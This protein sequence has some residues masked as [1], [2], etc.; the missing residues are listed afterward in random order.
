MA[1]V[2]TTMVSPMT[3]SKQLLISRRRKLLLLGLGMIVFIPL[4]VHKWSNLDVEGSRRDVTALCDE[5]NGCG[6]SA[7]A[8]ERRILIGGNHCLKYILRGTVFGFNGTTR[9]F[10]KTV[11]M[12]HLKT[13][14]VNVDDVRKTFLEIDN[15]FRF[16]FSSPSFLWYENKMALTLRLKLHSG[17]FHGQMCH[18]FMCNQ[19]HFGYY[20]EYLR[21]IG[22]PDII[23]LRT[24]YIPSGH[25]QIK[26]GPHDGK[27]FQMNGSLYILFATGIG[28]N[29][30]SSI[31]DFQ[32]QQ[33][34]TPY[35]MKRIM[36]RSNDVVM[37][38]NWVPVVVKDEL[39][40]IRY[41]D[42]LQVMK[43]KIH[44]GCRFVRNNTRPLAFKMKDRSFPIRG[45]TEFKEYQYPYYISI[46]HN[47]YIGSGERYYQANLVVM[48]V[49]PF[50][51]VYVS[52]RLRLK[53]NVFKGTKP[54][55]TTVAANFIFPTGLIIEDRNTIV[56]GAHAND[57]FSMLLRLTGI[58]PIVESVIEL[59]RGNTR[60]NKRLAIQR[61]FN[62][63][64]KARH[65]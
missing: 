9:I 11:Q 57:Q 64:S 48:C 50:R 28:E 41:L 39:Y 44:E 35:F 10:N 62:K 17:Y 32:R 63:R 2:F 13:F 47:T 61:F 1:S 58:Q 21:P 3:I 26:M 19:I 36:K 45:G 8:N 42:P 25:G 65:L 24:P 49:E 30:I 14:H 53:R 5:T 33:F 37:E 52:D 55:W 6:N 59:D 43:C 7:K 60:P 23:T 22:Q 12:C 16:S 34:F 4:S 56:I 15:K 38:K 31:W 51:I 27:L 54:K 29:F 20:D 46:A 18:N 40:I